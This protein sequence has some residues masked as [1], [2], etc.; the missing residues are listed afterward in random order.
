[1]V[2]DGENDL[3]ETYVEIETVRLK[4]DKKTCAWNAICGGK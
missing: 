3:K 4:Y 2:M 1:M